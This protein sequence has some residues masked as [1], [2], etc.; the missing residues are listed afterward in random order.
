MGVRTAERMRGVSVLMVSLRRS[1]KLHYT[2]MQGRRLRRR[3]KL[4][5][6]ALSAPQEATL[7][8]GSSRR[9]RLAFVGAG[10]IKPRHRNAQQAVIH[11][12][13]RSMMDKM[14]KYHSSK[15]RNARHVE[16][17]LAAGKQF[18]VLHHF[19]IAH[20]GKRG[21]RF[22]D[23]LVEFREQLFSV[24][25]LWRLVAWAIRVRVIR[26]LGVDGHWQPSHHAGDMAGQPADG[27]GFLVWF[28][29][30]F[31]IGIAFEGLAR[32]LHLLVELTKH[33][34][35]NGHDFLPCEG[36]DSG[37]PILGE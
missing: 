20:V 37:A 19:R 5:G 7:V 27:S 13:L 29:V 1:G 8:R 24:F 25:N 4:G 28:P 2:A 36:C 15:A 33:H 16:N 26:L 11:R 34:L 31:V 14:V 32:A 30:P 10:T 23:I 22:G 17:F 12:E 18:P 21:A 3:E 35:S 9:P 6:G